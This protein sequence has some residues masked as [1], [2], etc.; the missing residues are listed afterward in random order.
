MKP[1]NPIFDPKNMTAIYTVLFKSYCKMVNVHDCDAQL[2]VI[3][4]DIDN[5]TNQ[6]N[7]KFKHIC[8]LVI[9]YI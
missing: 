3:A 2:E 8:V 4:V 1:L 9:H 7:G 5:V 6:P